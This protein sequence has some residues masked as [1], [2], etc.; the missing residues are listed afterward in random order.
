MNFWAVVQTGS[1][2]VSQV[3]TSDAGWFPETGISP[4]TT[5]VVMRA[6]YSTTMMRPVI[7]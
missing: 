1:D 3:L 5:A 4:P 2:V 6:S 7:V